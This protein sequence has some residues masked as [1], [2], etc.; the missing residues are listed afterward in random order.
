M[1]DTAIDIPLPPAARIYV[2]S[3]SALMGVHPKRT[4]N[5]VV[6]EIRR[7]RNSE[8]ST[9][10]QMLSKTAYWALVG[11][12]KDVFQ[13][14]KSTHLDT[15]RAFVNE[16]HPD[17]WYEKLYGSLRVSIAG[18]DN[19]KTLEYPLTRDKSIILCGKPDIID[20][21]TI[22]DIKRTTKFDDTLKEDDKIR[23]YCYMKI[24]KLKTG[25]LREVNG[26]ETRDTVI[27]W[28]ILY[29]RKIHKLIVAFVDFL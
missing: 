23:L 28:D 17:S 21:K 18:L 5:D 19:Q 15:I 27:E 22:I 11:M 14:P 10:T 8:Q 1:T 4:A 24:C 6:K 9:T 2:S 7:Q 12:I 16:E 26:I 29:W 13:E 25:I 20:G 3:V